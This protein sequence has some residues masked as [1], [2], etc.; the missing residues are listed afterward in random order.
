MPFT[1]FDRVF[2]K[3]ELDFASNAPTTRPVNFLWDRWMAG[4]CAKFI[5]WWTQSAIGR[6]TWFLS[7]IA[8]S[9]SQTTVARFITKNALHIREPT[10]VHQTSSEAQ[11]TRTSRRSTACST[12]STRSASFALSVNSFR[13][14]RV[15]KFRPASRNTRLS[16][17]R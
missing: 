8:V 4:T 5:Q 1:P 13:M 9:S 7:V 11:A 17:L 2:L 14:E 16:I 12:R 6:R 10:I 15:S 3:K